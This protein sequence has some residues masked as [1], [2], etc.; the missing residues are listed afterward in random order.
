MS[1]AQ[2]ALLRKPTLA[3]ECT[4]V[5]LTGVERCGRHIRRGKHPDDKKAAF[6]LAAQYTKAASCGAQVGVPKGGKYQA[7]LSTDDKEFG[8][9]GRIDHAAAHLSQPEGQPGA[10]WLHVLGPVTLMHC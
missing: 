1:G 5:K 4:D 6:S 10:I 7:I 9:Q 2:H 8:G 3:A